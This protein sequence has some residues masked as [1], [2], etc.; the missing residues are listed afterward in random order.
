MAYGGTICPLGESTNDDSFSVKVK[1]HLVGLELSIVG[2]RGS[3][4]KDQY[5][6][7]KMLEQE[8]IKVPIATTL[9]L[10]DVRKAHQLVE[11]RAVVG[12]VLLHPWSAGS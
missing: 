12:K 4:L 6:F 5:L 10:S 8:K 11:E 2:I 3:Q 1:K 7:L 9:P